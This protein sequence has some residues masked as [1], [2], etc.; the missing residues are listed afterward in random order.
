MKY[1]VELAKTI[2]FIIFWLGLFWPSCFVASA[3]LFLVSLVGDKFGRNI[4]HE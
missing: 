1:Y 4:T 3:I 2:G